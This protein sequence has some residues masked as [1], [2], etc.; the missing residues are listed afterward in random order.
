MAN[1]ATRLI[2]LIMLLQRQPRQKAADLAAELGV[3]TRTVHRYVAALEEMGLPVYT[4]RGPQGGFSLVRGY[5]MPP[6]VFTP[7]EA[8]ALYLGTSLVEALWGKLY[9]EGARGALAKLDNVLPDEQRQEVAWARRTLV[10]TG[11]HR[12]DSEGLAPLLETLRRATRERRTVTMA[13]RART[14]PEP[15][16]RQVAPYALVHRWGWWYVVGFCR[17]RGAVRTFRVDRIEAL[18]L[19]EETFSRPEGFDVHAYLAA[20]PDTQPHVTAR[21]RFAP[22]FAAVALENRYLWQTMAEQPDG[23]VVVSLAAPDLAW[24]A[25]TVLTF[26]GCAVVLAPEA[27]RRLVRERAEA[28]AAQHAALTPREEEEQ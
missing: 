25:S 20:E 18:T 8:V 14:R 16:R 13:Y 7:E 26:S 28:I 3:S 11:L 1:T 22:A 6:L 2:T 23:A 19:G 17:L 10:A 9:E 27:L 15:T 12:A 5:R 24:A 4:E 21:L